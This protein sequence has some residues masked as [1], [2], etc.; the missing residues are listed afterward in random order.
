MGGLGG[1]ILLNFM[2]LLFQKLLHEGPNLINLLLQKRMITLLKQREQEIAGWR[3]FNQKRE[4]KQY[5]NKTKQNKRREL[6]EKNIIHEGRIPPLHT[7]IH[8]SNTS[9]NLLRKLRAV[10]F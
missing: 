10:K 5:K 9:S 8:I 7:S 6:M 2:N 4:K 3:E 1:E